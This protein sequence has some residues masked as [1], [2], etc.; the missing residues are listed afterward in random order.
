[1]QSQQLLAAGRSRPC[2]G[3]ALRQQ[4]RKP[5]LLCR[6]NS[7]GNG[8]TCPTPAETARTVADL[9]TEGSLCTVTADGLPLAVP[10]A[11]SLDAAGNPV[12][13]LVAG[14]A[15]ASALQASRRCSLLVQPASFPARSLGSVALQGAAAAADGQEGAP[16]GSCLV[17]LAVDGA[18]YYGGLDAAAHGLAVPGEEYHAA[19][20]DLLR[21]SASTLI[22]T[23]NSERAEDIY[24]IV[25]L[26]L[27]VPLIEMLY[28]ELLW[29]DRLGMYVRAEVLGRQP[30][31]VRVPFHRP[32]LDER[33]AR[34]VVTMASH[35]SWEADRKYVPPP[36]P[37]PTPAGSN[38]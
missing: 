6:A 13:Q 24:R 34:S 36:L 7:N 16:S 31:V 28:A 35:I 27:G 21:Q 14:S 1:M 22:N 10:V 37:T 17:T 29:V 3:V 8:V 19:E 2:L 9:C 32:V 18:T 11:Y 23:W 12:L 5:A 38:N 33:D 20:P 26:Q 15:E 4:L 25:A 30:A